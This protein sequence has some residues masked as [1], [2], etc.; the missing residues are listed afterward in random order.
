MSSDLFAA[1]AIWGASLLALVT[2]LSCLAL[3]VPA[4]FAMLAAGA[5]TATGDLSFL[6]VA[7]A[8]YVGAVAG[9]QV[10]YALGRLGQ[11][12]LE[13]VLATRPRRRMLFDRARAL[14]EKHGGPGIFFSRWLVS[15]LGPYANLAAG[16]TGMRHATFTF[17]GM[18]GEAVWVLLYT[19]LGRLFAQ[20]IDMIADIAGSITGLAA[21]LALVGVTGYWM[22]RSLRRPR[23]A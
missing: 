1:V 11:A 16:L 19:G 3:P 17:W 20:N 8:A 23:N 10:G 15:P 2:F 18:T 14:T 5:F 22:T 7:L 21:A 12:P 4:S 13:R 9:D 6:T